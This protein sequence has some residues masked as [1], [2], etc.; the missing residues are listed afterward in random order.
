MMHLYAMQLKLIL[1]LI[2]QVSA[3]FNS[4]LYTYM[5][6]HKEV[7]QSIPG[8]VIISGF[9]FVYRVYPATFLHVKVAYLISMVD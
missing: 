3:D 7:D 8:G 2:S 5:Y 6:I 9:C 1:S 4:I